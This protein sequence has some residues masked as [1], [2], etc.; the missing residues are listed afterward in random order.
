MGQWGLLLVAAL[1]VLSG[2]VI[3]VLPLRAERRRLRRRLEAAAAQLQH[4]Q[5]SF[6]RFAPSAVVEGI[7]ARGRPGDAEKKEV[8]ILF[9]DL[10]AFTALSEVLSP[11]VLVRV[12]NEYFV[13]M[14]RVIGEHRGHVSKFIGDGLMAL[15]GALEPNPWQ[16]NDAVHAALAMHGALRAYN[17]ELEA[18]GLPALRLGVGIH[19]GSAIAGVI[20]SHELLEF[21]VIGRTVNLAAR[22]E[23]LTRVHQA[24]ILVTAAVRAALDPRFVLEELPAQ[25]V[26]GVAEP[27]VAYAVR[28]VRD[29]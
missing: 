6:A 3:A 14:S 4:L 29:V 10:V 1:L 13:R 27:V 2:A 17:E 25:R 19:R 8:T 7:V 24:E 9:A 20:G 11:E 5:T 28:G 18:K 15:F 26:R 21:T 23:H 12:L 22:V 16:A